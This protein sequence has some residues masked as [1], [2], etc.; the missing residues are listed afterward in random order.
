MV[1]QTKVI[2]TILDEGLFQERLQ[3]F[4]SIS[5]VGFVPTLPSLCALYYTPT[6]SLLHVG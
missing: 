5:K 1:A 4:D 6:V 2:T 3:L